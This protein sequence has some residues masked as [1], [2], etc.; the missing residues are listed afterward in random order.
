MKGNRK[1]LLGVYYLTGLFAVAVLVVVKGNGDLVSVA[2]LAA[3][4]SSGLGAV[5]WGNVQERRA[6][7]PGGNGQA[8]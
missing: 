8:K 4:L 6:E 2:A 1:L 5:I 3:G 7:N